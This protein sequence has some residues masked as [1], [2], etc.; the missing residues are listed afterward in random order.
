MSTPVTEMSAVR[1]AAQVMTVEYDT[2]GSHATTFRNQNLFKG[3]PIGDASGTMGVGFLPGDRG[4][5]DAGNL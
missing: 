1:R 5:G 4:H 2:Q 3:F